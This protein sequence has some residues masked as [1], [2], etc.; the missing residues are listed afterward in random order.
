[1]KKEFTLDE[2]KGRIL[3][4]NNAIYNLEHDMD[5]YGFGYEGDESYEELQIQM[6]GQKAAKAIFIQE[7]ENRFGVIW[8]D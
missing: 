6:D 1:M 8:E 2:L 7:M 5:H 4:C 3:N